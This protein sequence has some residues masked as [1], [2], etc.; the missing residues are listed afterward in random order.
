V[1]RIIAIALLP[2]SACDDTI[3]G[4]C[5]VD[6]DCQFG[7]SSI[8]YEGVCMIADEDGGE[9]GGESQA[10]GSV[11]DAGPQ[12]AEIGDAGTLAEGDG[13]MQDAG[14]QNAGLKVLGASCSA[15]GQC[16][17]GNCADGVCCDSPCNDQICQRCDNDSL[18]GPGRCG[19]ARQ[20]TDRDGEC[21]TPATDG[22][23]GTCMV[24]MT[25]AS[26]TGTSYTC[27][28]QQVIAAV[29]SGSVCFD[30]AVQTVS[31]TRYCDTGNDCADGKCQALRWWTSC[32]SK[33][34]CRSGSDRKDAFV[35]TVNAAA[36]ATLTGSCETKGQSLCLAN[37]HCSGDALSFGL[38]CDGAGQCSI[39]SAKSFS[40]G[41]YACNA[42]TNFCQSQ[43]STDADCAQDFLCT[44]SDC[45]W[46]WEWANWPVSGGGLKAN[47][48]TV[49]ATTT[50]LEW[51]RGVSD[52]QKNWE[53]AKAY[54]RNLLLSGSGWRLP[55][56]IELLSIADSPNSDACVVDNENVFL[57]SPC[58]WFWT[59]TPYANSSGSAWC[60]DFTDGHSSSCDTAS[61]FWV[62]CVR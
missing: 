33:G 13:G 43:C 23:S 16:A 37:P 51:Q 50:G 56:R 7:T 40:C 38:L 42:S 49:N 29:P 1:R 35:E 19:V 34:K 3:P 9:A 53:E 5:K 47:A 44:A 4:L 17:S 24:S 32:D 61:K 14:P 31:K 21:P 25:T 54:C 30:N 48:S 36:G 18:S 15:P 12:D 10:D 57:D 41:N 46:D 45:H 58:E 60:I 26:C 8:C 6:S 27:A 59:S 11:G 22:C 20:G 62:R 52:S 2:F 39:D 55:T 28:K